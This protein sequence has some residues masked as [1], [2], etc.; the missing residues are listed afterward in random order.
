MTSALYSVA[1]TVRSDWRGPR[2][3]GRGRIGFRTVELDT[4]PDDDGRPYTLKVNGEAV[5]IKGV[6][7]IPDEA[8]FGG[9]D[10]ARIERRLRQAVAAGDQ[11][12]PRVG[13]RRLRVR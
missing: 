6:N 7:W 11:L 1:V 13:R 10:P 9:I 5:W 8:L 12:H 4:E 3:A 2:R